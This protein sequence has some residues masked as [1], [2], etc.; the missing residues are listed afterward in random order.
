MRDL[1]GRPIYESRRARQPELFAPRSFFAVGYFDAVEGRQP[2][3]RG[4]AAYGY[5][6]EAGRRDLAAGTVDE[7]RAW[8]ANVAVGNVTEG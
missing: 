1:F 2:D 5:G 7:A 6:F 4:C 3:S 8:R